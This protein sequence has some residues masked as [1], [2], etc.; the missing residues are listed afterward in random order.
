MVNREIIGVGGIAGDLGSQVAVQLAASDFA[1]E[2]FDV[3]PL[4]Q[5]NRLRGMDLVSTLPS[6]ADITT[7][8][9]VDELFVPDRLVHW[10][11]PLSALG[12]VALAG[13]EV[14]VLHDSV[15]QRSVTAADELRRQGASVA[16]VHCLMNQECKVA[17]NDTSDQK[18]RITQHFAA[19]GMSPVEMTTEQHDQL[20]ARTQMPLAILCEGL[21]PELFELAESGLLTPSG[22]ALLRALE[23]RSANWTNNTLDT[24]LSN[25]QADWL[26]ELLQGRVANR[27]SLAANTSH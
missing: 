26:F 4:P 23:D 14:I 27:R 17:V 11:A 8:P 2:G 22:Q 9:N 15:M 16:I 1:V 12:N 7:V 6:D 19:M 10:C 5:L 21:L 20:M 3:Q 13:G 25:P 24:I 18:D